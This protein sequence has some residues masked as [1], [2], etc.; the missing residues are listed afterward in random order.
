[1][2]STFLFLL[3]FGKPDTLSIEYLEDSQWKK[4]FAVTEVIDRTEN[5]IHYYEPTAWLDL[6]KQPIEKP[7]K[8]FIK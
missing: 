2:I 5:I 8:H 3:C 4:G 1:M 6:N 7:K